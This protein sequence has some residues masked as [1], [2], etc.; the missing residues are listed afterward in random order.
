MLWEHQAKIVVQAG[1]QEGR[2][3]GRRVGSKKDT[4]RWLFYPLKS[5]TVTD[6]A[7]VS[8]PACT[9]PSLMPRWY[10]WSWQEQVHRKLRGHWGPVCLSYLWEAHVL[11]PRQQTLIS[12]RLV[13]PSTLMGNVSRDG[14]KQILISGSLSAFEKVKYHTTQNVTTHAW[15]VYQKTAWITEFIGGILQ[16]CND[17]ILK[18][19]Y[20]PSTFSVSEF[21]ISIHTA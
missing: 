8:T 13:K 4:Q 18:L 1:G 21:I 15:Y 7:G 6:E 3:A 2:Q 20:Y 19:R 17:K 5:A 12:H 16:S 10:H 14:S 11:T 9:Y